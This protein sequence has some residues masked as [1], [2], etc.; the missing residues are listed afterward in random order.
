MKYG[1]TYNNHKLTIQD[2]HT[3]AISRGGTCLSGLYHNQKVK[4]QWQCEHGHRWWAS[5]TSIVHLNSWCPVCANNQ[6]LT[7]GSMQKLAA[8]KG[9]KCLSEHYHNSKTKLLWECDKGHRWYALPYSLKN[10]NSWC[11]MCFKNDLKKIKI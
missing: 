3:K 1:K 9:G 10:R 6:K 2:M 7:I 4:L 8:K 11:P 5:P